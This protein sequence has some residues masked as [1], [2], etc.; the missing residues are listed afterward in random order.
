[1]Q[2]NSCEISIVVPFLDEEGSLEELHRQITE[3]LAYL[4]KDYEIIFVDDGSTDKSY[5]IVEKLFEKDNRIEV[6]KFRRNFGK[7]AALQ[8]GID[9][10]RGKLI[11]TMDADLQDSPSEIPKFIEALDRGFDVVSGWKETR[12]DPMDKTLPSKLFNWTT[13]KISGV[14]IHDF[15]C[16]FKIYRR[17]VFEEVELYGELHRYIPVLASW[18]GFTVSEISVEHRA[19]EFGKSKYGLERIFKGF[20]DLIT[21][22]FTRRFERR[23]L[24]IFGLLGL[25]F[26]AAGF[27]VLFYLVLLWFFGGGPIG[28]RP[29]LFLSI[30]SITFGGQLVFFGLLAEMFI[31]FENKFVKGFSVSERMSHNGQIEKDGVRSGE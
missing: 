24:H 31:K 30:F 9:I 17:E 27:A 23:P 8:A 10:A 29:L 18:K 4:G 26:A 16:G 15:N 7:A 1:M 21:I 22:V 2:S 3:V 6:I 20:F 5:S 19:R 13:R 12:N 14:D 28:Q 25:S 11:V